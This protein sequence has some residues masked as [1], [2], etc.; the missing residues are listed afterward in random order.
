MSTSTKSLSVSYMVI[1]YGIIE[2]TARL[3]MHKIREA[4]LTPWM[5]IYVDE[6]VIGGKNQDKI[7]RSYHNKKK[8]AVTGFS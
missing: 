6:F 5:E 1:R 8:K 3:F 7:G 4:M 2:T